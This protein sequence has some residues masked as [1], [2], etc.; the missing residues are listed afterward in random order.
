MLPVLCSSLPTNGPSHSDPATMC[1]FEIAGEMRER[2]SIFG[3][4]SVTGSRKGAQD[5]YVY[6]LLARTKSQY[7]I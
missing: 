2:R 1:T 6:I 4:I 3:H 5:S 7:H